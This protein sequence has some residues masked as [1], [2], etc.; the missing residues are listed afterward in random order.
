MFAGIQ[1]LSTGYPGGYSAPGQQA[2]LSN[3]RKQAI[4]LPRIRMAGDPYSQTPYGYPQ[5]GGAAPQ[6]MGAADYQKW[7]CQELKCHICSSRILFKD[8]RLEQGL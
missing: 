1:P 5:M 2:I 4:Q 3:T 8:Y 6:V 7:E